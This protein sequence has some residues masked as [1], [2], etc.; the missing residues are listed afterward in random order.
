MYFAQIEKTETKDQAE[1]E[2]KH[3]K[4]EDEKGEQSK[5]PVKEALN[6]EQAWLREQLRKQDESRQNKGT[7]KGILEPP[8]LGGRKPGPQVG[9]DDDYIHPALRIVRLNFLQNYPR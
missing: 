4:E 9:P 5:W 8:T 2:N 7:P 6:K 3:A 1:K